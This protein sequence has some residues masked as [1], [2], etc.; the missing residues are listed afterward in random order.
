[1]SLTCTECLSKDGT[2]CS[3][4]SVTCP[5][6]E[7]C[8]SLAT[9][10]SITGMNNMN[11]FAS[12]CA[13]KQECDVSGSISI[14]STKMEFA[15]SCCST[16]KCTPAK[17]KLPDVTKPNGVVCPACLSVN[18]NP[19][20]AGER[21]E[22]AGNEKMCYLETTTLPDN[23]GPVSL[24]GCASKSVCDLVSMSQTSIFKALNISSSIQCTNGA[25]DHHHGFLLP[26]IIVSALFAFMFL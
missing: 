14:T 8:A 3:G 9:R 19:C 26:A 5:S 15:S 16:D 22:C 13:P 12:S 7:V 17:P 1:Y 20:K 21:M 2:T 24:H 18:S 4:P 10:V 6:N 25:F 11:L 23:S